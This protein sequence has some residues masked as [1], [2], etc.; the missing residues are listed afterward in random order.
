MVCD[1]PSSF[2]NR[3]TPLKNFLLCGLNDFVM[4]LLS[5]T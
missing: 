3:F 1:V 5:V 4:I 2:D